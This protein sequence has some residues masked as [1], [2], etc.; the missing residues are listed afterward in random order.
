MSET[1]TDVGGARVTVSLV[2][3][4]GLKWLPGCFASI[5]AQT[6]RPVEILV[7]D[8]ASSDGTVEWLRAEAER[9][10]RMRLYESTENLGFAKAHNRNIFQARGEFVCLLNQDV[11]L[12]PVFLSEAVGAFTGRPRVAA[13]QGRLRRL[14]P[15]GEH[16]A[17]LDSTGLVMYRN[18]RVLSRS[19]GE[20]DCPRHRKPGP[21]WG[22]DGPAPI[23]RRTALLQTRLPAST[24]G[25]EV[26]DEDFFMYKED[27]DLA[28]RLRNMG[29][30]AW[31]APTALAWHARG[32]GKSLATTLLTEIRAGRE[33]P[34]WV[35]N[36]SWRNHRLM[37]VK[38]EDPAEYIRGLP[39]IARREVLSLGYMLVAEPRRLI[40]LPALLA[41]LPRTIRKRQ[42]LARQTSSGRSLV[43]AVAAQRRERPTA[44]GKGKS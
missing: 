30:S 38:N 14:G 15:H 12:D 33:I 7:V 40:S 4:N 35:K 9:N 25:W 27:V 23:Y 6:L 41:A 36:V 24:G 32:A 3:F 37:Q 8:N 28:W 20:A 13:V 5:R 11:E 1:D 34:H 43:T 19:Q 18:R 21:V 22:A 16:T 31:Y 26:L 2:T 42:Y 17:I 10:E 29:W 44:P 39:W